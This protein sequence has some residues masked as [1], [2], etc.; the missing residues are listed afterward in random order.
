M[1]SRFGELTGT[2]QQAL[3]APGIV[4]DNQAMFDRDLVLVEHFQ[5]A[6][7]NLNQVIIW[8]AQDTFGLMAY[9]VEGDVHKIA[10]QVSAPISP[11]TP[12]H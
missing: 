5:V 11:D 12:P 2:H 3:F 8:M 6:I 1:W 7:F 9:L 4:N 10:F